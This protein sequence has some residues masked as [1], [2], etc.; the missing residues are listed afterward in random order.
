MMLDSLGSSFV[1][2]FGAFF[3]VCLSEATLI[4]TTTYYIEERAITL[5]MSQVLFVQETI[6]TVSFYE[7]YFATET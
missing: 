4:T 2:I 5:A 3:S 7:M 1:F 6:N